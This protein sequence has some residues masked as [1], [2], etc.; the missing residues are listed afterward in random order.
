MSRGS[1]RV[2]IRLTPLAL[3]LIVQR[4][5]TKRIEEQENMKHEWPTKVS[6]LMADLRVAKDKLRKAKERESRVEH[7]SRKLHEQ[8][9]RLQQK[10]KKLQGQLAT[11]ERASGAGGNRAKKKMVRLFV[12]CRA[13]PCRASGMM[14]HCTCL[15]GGVQPL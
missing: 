3:Q 15:A 4:N 9:V 8:M 2:C 14:A 13:V 5:Q 12:P 6:S 11:H 1:V 10:N 7:D